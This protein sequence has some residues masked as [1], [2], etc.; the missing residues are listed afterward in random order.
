LQS[1]QSA[2]DLTGWNELASKYGFV[3]LYPQ[4]QWKNNSGLCFNWFRRKDIK[5]GR[6][7]CESVYQMIHYMMKQYKV[8]YEKIFITGLS[9]GAAMSVVMLST[10]P[11]MF[12]KGVVFAGGP[13]G[14]AKNPIAASHYMLGIKPVNKKKLS[15]KVMKMNPQYSG[16][17]PSLVI[18]QGM[19]DQVS[20]RR[21]TRHLTAQWKGLFEID[22]NR[23]VI[24]KNYSGIE[25]MTRIDY[26]DM[27]GRVCVSVIEVQGLGH[28]LLIK[29]GESDEEGGKPGLFSAEI[30]YH[31]TWETA[32]E[33]GIVDNEVVKE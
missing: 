11:E 9:A 10:H 7:E 28:K 8:N 30:G 25:A 2:A 20:G 18:Y 24:E 4:Q 33:F 6:G 29:P 16:D 14:V 31:S 12:R 5:K 26:Y 17:Y 32:V 1:A 21:N 23:T 3:M 13:Y 22:D 27:S 15:K 19:S